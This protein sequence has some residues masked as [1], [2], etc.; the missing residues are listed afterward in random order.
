MRE[1]VRHSIGLRAAKITLIEVIVIVVVLVAIVSLLI[2]ILDGTQDQFRVSVCLGNLKNIYAGCESYSQEYGGVIATGVRP[3][4][5]P[6]D[7]SPGVSPDARPAFES[8]HSRLF[9]WESDQGPSVT[10]GQMQRYW[11]VM[12]SRWIATAPTGGP[13]GRRNDLFDAMF[14]PDDKIYPALAEASESSDEPQFLR[15]SYLMTEAAFW[16]PA[17]FSSEEKVTSIFAANQLYEDDQGN[18]TP[19]PATID[20]PG[21]IYMPMSVVRY[22]SMK[23]YIWEANAFHDQP[24]HGYNERGLKASVLFFD[25]H[26]SYTEASKS[27]DWQPRLYWPVRSRM[28]WTDKPR[29]KDDPLWAYYSLTVDGLLGRDFYEIQ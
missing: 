2:P 27:E 25:G 8:N 16:S 11:Y 7:W 29:D 10:Y 24:A 28:A 6:A 20:T 23:A 4:P 12:M 15:I 14:C 26:A 17:M 13:G 1:P 19:S 22:P 9:G 21:R 3:A 5:F 18:T